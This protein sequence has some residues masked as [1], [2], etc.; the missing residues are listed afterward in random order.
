MRWRLLN[1]DLRRPL[2]AETNLSRF[3]RQRFIAFDA[4]CRELIEALEHYRASS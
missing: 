4:A 1:L 2:M 3:V